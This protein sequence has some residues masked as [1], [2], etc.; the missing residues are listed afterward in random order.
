MEFINPAF[1]DNAPEQEVDYDYPPI[2]QEPP[3]EW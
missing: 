2:K 3:A 1:I